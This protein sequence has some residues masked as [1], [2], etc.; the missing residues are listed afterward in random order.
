[1]GRVQ[2]R[3]RDRLRACCTVDRLRVHFVDDGHGSF[4]LSFGRSLDDA[5]WVPSLSLRVLG[6]FSAMPSV[7][8]RERISIHTCDGSMPARCHSATRW[9]SSSALLRPTPRSWWL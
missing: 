7:S 8:A 6:G 3:G 2:D 1:M 9:W 5:D 4:L